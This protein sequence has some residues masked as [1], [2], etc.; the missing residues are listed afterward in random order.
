MADKN[1]CKGLHDASSRCSYR[2][3]EWGDCGHV[4]SLR[5]MQ[6]AR[7]L[8]AEGSLPPYRTVYSVYTIGSGG[9]AREALGKLRPH[10]GFSAAGIG[11]LLIFF[12]FL[13][14]VAYAGEGCAFVVF[15]SSTGAAV[16]SLTFRAD[17]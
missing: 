6:G 17:A 1:G 13:K 7:L 11:L 9:A 5:G 2:G 10:P 14:R 12:L 16:R 15:H 4:R 8:I 3:D